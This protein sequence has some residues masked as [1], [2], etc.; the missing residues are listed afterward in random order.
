MHDVINSMYVLFHTGSPRS[1]PEALGAA[2]GRRDQVLQGSRRGLNVLI[3]IE[4]SYRLQKEIDIDIG[5]I[6]V[7]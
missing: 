1:P 5:Y 2:P 6:D 3:D 4:I 7:Q